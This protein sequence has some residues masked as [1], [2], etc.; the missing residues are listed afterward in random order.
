MSSEQREEIPPSD[1]EDAVG[2]RPTTGVTVHEPAEVAES[3]PDFEASYSEDGFWAKVGKFAV[4]AGEEVIRKALV[5]YYCLQDA[6]TPKWAKTHIVF[7]LGYFIF[8]VDAIPDVVPVVGFSDDLGVLVLA[9]A[10]V[11]AHI[12]QAHREAAAKQLEKLFGAA[13]A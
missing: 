7:A 8:P 13:N 5:L 12:K 3:A 4:K 1:V 10:M 9:V 11:V 6:D 2:E